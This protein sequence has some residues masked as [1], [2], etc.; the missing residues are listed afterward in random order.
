MTIEWPG[1]VEVHSRVNTP[2]R[3][4]VLVDDVPVLDYSTWTYTDSGS[5]SV[6]PDQWEST[7]GL[8]PAV[9]DPVRITVIPE[10]TTGDWEVKIVRR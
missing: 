4:Q 5:Q 6:P 1:P 2:G 3:I 10:R 9:G 8:K 7:Y